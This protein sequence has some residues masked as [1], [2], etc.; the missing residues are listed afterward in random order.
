[1]AKKRRDKERDP[2]SAQ[3]II[4]AGRAALA[5]GAGVALFNNS[6]LKH[7]LRQVMPAI[8]STR[9]TFR[10]ELLNKKKT[11][12]NIY[13]AYDKA[14]GKDGK[15][16]KKTL[17]ES[18]KLNYDLKF[19]NNKNLFG[20]RLEQHISVKTSMYERAHKAYEAELTRTSLNRIHSKLGDKYGKDSYKFYN[21][22]VQSAKEQRS[23]LKEGSGYNIEFLRNT[24]DKYKI[25]EQDAKFMVGVVHS[26]FENATKADRKNFINTYQTL[27][28]EIL[29]LGQANIEKRTRDNLLL[30]KIGKKLGFKSGQLEELVMGSKAVTF[31]EFLNDPDLLKSID[32]NKFK[33]SIIDKRTG[34]EVYVD[35]LSEFEELYNKDPDKIK[36]I[37]VD[38]NLR[39]RTKSDG[40]KEIYSTQFMDDFK[41]ELIDKW[42]SSL[43]GKVLTKGIDIKNIKDAPQFYMFIPGKK[44]LTAA[45]DGTADNIT[46]ETKIVMN[47]ILYSL[48]MDMDG[49]HIGKELKKGFLFSNTHGTLSGINRRTLG[50]D[51]LTPAASFNKVMQLLDIN[52]DGRSNLL[53]EYLQYFEKFDNPDWERNSIGRQI[54]RLINNRD[55]EGE[56]GYL[57]D[58]LDVSPLEAM[59]RMH[60]DNQLINDLFSKRASNQVVSNDTIQSLISTLE[61]VNA[62]GFAKEIELLKNAIDTSIEETMDLLQK[63]PIKTYSSSG[64]QKLL[65][66]YKEN[67]IEFAKRLSIESSPT[68]KIPILDIEMPVTNVSGPEGII[69]TEILKE[70]LSNESVLNSFY[71]QL[72]ET[73]KSQA[74]AIMNLG[75]WQRFQNATDAFK[76]FGSSI[77]SLYNQGSKLD[78]FYQEVAN[79]DFMKANLFTSFVDMSNE[80]GLMHKGNVGNINESYYSEFEN[81]DFMGKSNI[82]KSMSQNIIEGIN[83]IIKEAGAGRHNANDISMLTYGLQYSMLR[84]SYGVESAGLGLSS[85]SLGSPLQ[86]FSSIF[87]KRILPAMALYTGLDYL[88]DLSQDTLG[89][90]F[91]GAGANTVANMDLFGRRIAYSTGIGQALDWFKQTS[92]IGEYL[93]GSTDFQD[94][95]ERADWYKNGY[96]PVRKS[97]FWSFGSASEFRGGDITFFQPNFYRRAHSDYRDEW[98]YGGNKEK[99][100]HSIIPTPTHPLS[101]IRYLMDPYWLEKKHMDDAPTPLTGKMFSEGTPWGAILNP[102]IGEVIKPQIMLPEVRQR[103]T[104]KGH[105]SQAIIKR[106]NERIKERGLNRKGKPSNDDLIVVNGTDIRNATYVPYGNPTANEINI[107][108]GYIR[109]KDYINNVP[110]MDLYEAPVYNPDGYDAENNAQGVYSYGGSEALI[111]ISKSLNGLAYQMKKEK[112]LGASL[113]ESI[114]NSI[115]QKAYG[116]AMSSHSPDSSREGTYYYNNLINEYN[117]RVANYYD[118]QA[119]PQMLDTNVYSDYMRDAKHSLKNLLGIYGFIGEKAF[120]DGSFT[121]RYENAGSYM[122]FSKSFWDA[123]VGGLGGNVM[124]IARRFFPS[125]DKSRVD[126]NPLRNNLADWLPDYLQIGNPFSK[127]TKGE[128]R[129]PGKGYESL[130]ELHPDEFATDGYG[131]FDRYKILA[132]VAPN[133]NEY[134]IWKNIAKHTIKDPY[135]IKE[136]E[137]IEARTKRMRGSHEFYDYQYLNSNTKY[138]QGVVKE[139]RKNGQIVLANNQVL[140][141]AGINLNENYNG[142]LA[143]FFNPG[144][145]ISYRTTND[146]IDSLEKGTIR[147]A[148][149]YQGT[150][151]INKKL[152]DMGVADR[153]KTDTSAIGQ[154]A[155]VSAMQEILGGAQELLAHARIPII[156]NKLLHIETPLEAFESEQI[157]GAN[158]QTW[159]HPIEGFV[160]PMMNEVMGQSIFRRAAA[161]AYSD[162]HFNKVLKSTSRTGKFASGLALATLD[163]SAMLFGTLN[164]MAKLNDGRVSRKGD[165]VLGSWSRGA[166]FGTAIGTAAWGL[167]NADNPLI[168]TTSFALAGIE[169]TRRFEL[170]DFAEKVLKKS[171]NWKKSA[172]IGAAIGFGISAIKNQGPISKDT[173]KKWQPAKYKKKNELY[174]YFDRLEYI[175]YKGLY[176]S[177]A[178]K[179]ALF[180]KTNIK[181]VFKTIDKNKKRIN[182]LKDK[183]KD[184]LKKYNENDSRYIAKSAELEKEIQALTERGN[185]MFT[186]G[187]YTKAA[188]AYKKAMESTIFGLSEGATQDEILA[189]VPDAYKD[190]YQAFMDETDENERKKILKKLPDYLQRP[191]QAAWG[192]KLNGTDSNRQYFKTH[193][194]PNMNWRGWKPNIN[195]KYVQMKTIQ[196]EGMLLSDFNFYESEKAKEAYAM[197]PDIENF[198]SGGGFGTL[199]NLKAELRGLG[200]MT[201]NISLEKTS[202]PGFWIASDIKQSISDRYEYGSNSVTNSI[203]G[204]ISNFI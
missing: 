88:N 83:S 43:P 160:K 153:D 187:K 168:A 34:E 68:H 105:D 96:S 91:A 170:G 166:R 126:Y 30:N 97:R 45:I 136:M 14:I 115:K 54:N 76:E 185:N 80:Y 124:E 177:A 113:I 70:V 183:R 78:N 75:L 161:I 77:E 62:T 53:K 133:S 41:N 87:T 191:L 63:S 121:Y 57:Q 82:A 93:T 142:E 92:V 162:F 141:L 175:K 11:A 164:W 184:L 111:P 23:F 109:G 58:T 26:T 52:Q 199:F 61:T 42:N 106:I 69:R 198:D 200:L 137:D 18:K 158:F 108:G 186:G 189:A 22:I 140:T 101:T 104:G 6:Q 44:S 10:N 202:T 99:W 150:D 203:Q 127:L 196:N 167:A 165:Q 67:P 204:F 24:I 2:S 28:S 118:D 95:E 40:T 21:H 7:N 25:D 147:N 1:M 64:L 103:L 163:P 32:R 182:K 16:F 197:A 194:L 151:N 5:V 181:D 19:T 85:K 172:A 123:G 17:E 157:N 89:T 148:A 8:D 107:T 146:A 15:V 33:K 60:E 86:T 110:T 190:F 201:S 179:A 27:E 139:V 12:L 71:M 81:F 90:G 74:E 79:N 9:K 125:S 66:S 36:D 72:L 50:E 171:L 117:T 13:N 192:M 152:M 154:L 49:L 195:L 29:K 3:R 51:R 176:E 132:D 94:E 48:D 131:A 130:N 180:E 4:K 100:K 56:L 39:I 73:D 178:R 155:T 144:D 159:D 59:R 112:S 31:E 119:T 143:Q 188:I 120:G 37:I 122:S 114:N 173:F 65:N 116:R 102:T 129:L 138:E 169:L 193:K 20:R 84:L 174:E 38:K 135:L 55:V 46:S 98:L 149:I 47:N 35:I 128:M 145:T 134:K 156:H